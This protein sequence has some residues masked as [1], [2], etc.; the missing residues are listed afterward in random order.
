MVVWGGEVVMKLKVKR[1][2]AGAGVGHHH[3]IFCMMGLGGFTQ[4]NDI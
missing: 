2:H 4:D 3:F 1:L